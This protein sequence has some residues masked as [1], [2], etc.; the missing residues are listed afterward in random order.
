M[1]SRL[2][3]IAALATVLLCCWWLA[4]CR[5]LEEPAPFHHDHGDASMEIRPWTHLDFHNSPENFQFAIVTD[6]TGG[7]RP[8]VFYS[9]VHKANL[10]QPEFIMSVGDLIEGYSTDL[11][12]LHTEWTAFRAM[13]AE[14]EMPFFYVPGNHDISNDTM[15]QLWEE[16][17]GARYYSFVYKDVLF[18]CL[19]SMDRAGPKGGFTAEQIAWAEKEIAKHPDVRWT[20]IFFHYPL[21]VFDEAESAVT[22]KETLYQS[23]LGD[24]E[25]VLADRPYTVF[26][27]HFHTYTCYV[28]SGQDYITLAT[29]G[30]RSKLL[31]PEHG[32]FDHIVWVSMTPRGP[33]IATLLLDGILPKDVYTEAHHAL[34][35]GLSVHLI[36]QRD[37]PFRLVFEMVVANPFQSSVSGSIDWSIPQNSGWSVAPSNITLSVDSGQT[38][39]FRFQAS[40]SGKPDMFFPLPH[41]IPRLEKE[42]VSLEGKPAPLSRAA[43]R[44]H[45]KRQR[46]GVACLRTSGAP[47]VDGRLDDPL[48]QRVPDIKELHA[49]NQISTASQQTSAWLGYDGK[50]LYIA[51]RC[52][53]ENPTGLRTNASDRDGL[54]WYDD[55]IELFIDT[56]LDRTTYFQFIVNAAGIQFDGKGLDASWNGEWEARTAMEEDGW[57]LE[58][59]IPWG[60][61]GMEAPMQNR[62]MGI[63]LVRNRPQAA[64]TKV[65]QWPP[66]L[67]TNHTPDM[68]ADLYC[69]SMESSK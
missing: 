29:T 26:S 32:Q 18:L 34:Q 20:F 30:G 53:E 27:G 66:T 1:I 36:E 46:P 55:S 63:L 57:I 52:E 48:W 2:L 6:R 42:G 44:A 62:R 49:I 23:G 3:K 10:L 39:A 54:C 61:L 4:G 40:F 64:D 56:D 11:E 14:L 43:I 22:E 69:T 58:T 28:R 47:Q 65:V 31:G 12:K 5:A 60:T 7:H 33:K 19:D 68:F 25:K 17:F 13:T 16:L 35:K 15:G 38:G 37:H 67:G 51:V 45:L 21:W 41:Y 50:N 9:A 8:G 24:I 59:A